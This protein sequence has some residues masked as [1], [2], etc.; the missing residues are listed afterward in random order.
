MLQDEPDDTLQKTN[1]IA[2]TTVHVRVRTSPY[3][4]IYVFSINHVNY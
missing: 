4:Q 1:I 2:Y 3:Q